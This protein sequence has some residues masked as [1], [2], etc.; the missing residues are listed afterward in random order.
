MRLINIKITGLFDLFS[1]SIDLNQEEDL[2]ILTSPNGYG[3]TTVLNIL[4][5]LFN[6]LVLL[7]S[8]TCFQRNNTTIR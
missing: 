6:S 2:T 7:F 1:Y 3:K 4:Y 8:E 5:N